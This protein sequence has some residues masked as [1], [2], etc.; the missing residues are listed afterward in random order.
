MRTLR[1]TDRLGL[2]GTV[3]I[4]LDSSP[5]NLKHN[6]KPIVK[7]GFQFTVCAYGFNCRN[8]I[9]DPALSQVLAHA[10][11]SI[12]SNG[13]IHLMNVERLFHATTG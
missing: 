10:L 2:V 6:L 12:D 3:L 9:V 4:Y 11:T 7:P 1:I 5:F 8:G 13:S